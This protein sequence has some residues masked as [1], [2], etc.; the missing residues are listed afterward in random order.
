MEGLG[1]SLSN[2]VDL[3]VFLAD[4]SQ[5]KEFNQAYNEYF[6]SESGP[7][8][9]TIGVAALPHPSLLIEIKAIGLLPKAK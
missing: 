4:M 7:S 1:S 5:Y 9:T 8:R 6:S 2:I 3:T